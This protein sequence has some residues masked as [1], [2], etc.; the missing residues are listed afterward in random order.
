[1]SLFSNDFTFSS[2]TL[3]YLHFNHWVR[4][5]KEKVTENSGGERKL[6]FA[7]VLAIKKMILGIN[8]FHFIIGFLLKY[9][10]LLIF[11]KNVHMAWEIFFESWLVLDFL[12]IKHYIEIR[13]EFIEVYEVFLMCF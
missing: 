3:F 7:H 1:M 12:M 6:L 4:E 8:K 11:K 5:K 13:Y 2:R 10:L 9:Y